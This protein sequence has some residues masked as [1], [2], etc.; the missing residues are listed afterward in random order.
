VNAATKL[1]EAEK[2]MNQYKINSL[3]VDENQ[4][5]VGIIQIYDIV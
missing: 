3:L 1:A 2:L 5:L 4:Q